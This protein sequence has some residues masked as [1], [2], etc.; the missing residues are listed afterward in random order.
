M[1]ALRRAFIATSIVLS[2]AGV[3]CGLYVAA[4]EAVV[5]TLEAKS[6]AARAMLQSSLQAGTQYMTIA[7]GHIVTKINGAMRGLSDAKLDEKLHSKALALSQALREYAGQASQA[8]ANLKTVVVSLVEEAKEWLRSD[9][10][11][12]LVGSLRDSALEVK[13][14]LR[15]ERPA[16]LA[17]TFREYVVAEAIQFKGWCRTASFG[18]LIAVACAG[19]FS[20]LVL[21]VVAKGLK[22]V[23]CRKRRLAVAPSNVTEDTSRAIAF[24][25]QSQVMMSPTPSKSM[26]PPTPVIRRKRTESPAPVVKPAA[27]GNVA[28]ERLPTPAYASSAEDLLMRLNASS[29]DDLRLLNG[30]GDKSV[31][32]IMRFRESNGCI[33]S[34]EDLVKKVGI[35]HATFSKFARAQGIQA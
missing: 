14:W 1:A 4:P 7:R 17:R 29:P 19:I 8:A 13:E 30:L 33:E 23:C 28:E 32:R 18:Q 35:H 16:E 21:V 25:F 27:S 15:S 31:D 10:P 2:L 6:L 12:E 5:E 3:F 9:R 26:R 22:A 20:I 11:A 34:L 24:D